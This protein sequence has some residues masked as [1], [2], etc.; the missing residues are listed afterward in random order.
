MPI[1]SVIFF[2]CL[3]LSGCTTIIPVAAWDKEYLA[4]PAMALDPD[5]LDR[6]FTEHVYFSREASSGGGGFGGG[7]C[8][9]N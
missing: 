4:E 2:L 8:G 1:R 3:G 6:R 5:P 7:G 9:C